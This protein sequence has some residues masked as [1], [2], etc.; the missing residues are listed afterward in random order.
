[1][2][3]D[4]DL[5]ATI[6]KILRLGCIPPDVEVTPSLEL[7]LHHL[8]LDEAFNVDSSGLAGLP[9]AFLGQRGGR[10]GWAK[11]KYGEFRVAFRWHPMISSKLAACRF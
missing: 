11:L 7:E 4:G 10:M 2:D 5:F 8:R 6:L 9:I 3:R 1:M